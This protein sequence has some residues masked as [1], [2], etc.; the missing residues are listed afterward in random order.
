MFVTTMIRQKNSSTKLF[1]KL[2]SMI[3]GNEEILFRSNVRTEFILAVKFG[4]LVIKFVS[5][6]NITKYKQNTSVKTEED[7]RIV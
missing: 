2:N 6:N 1:L 7:I 4:N 3:Y 5:F